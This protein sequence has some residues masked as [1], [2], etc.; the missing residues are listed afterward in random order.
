MLETKMIGNKIAEARKKLNISQAQL[1]EYLFIS[2]QA[3]GKWE[4]G[5]SMPDITTFNRLAEILGVDLNYFSDNFQSSA[6]EKRP[7]ESLI[8]QSADLQ[9]EKQTEKLSWNMS[10]GNWVDANF[11]GLENLHEKFSSSNM[12]RCKFIGSDLAGLL[13][14]SNNIDSCDFSGSD[15]QNSHIQNSHLN[16]NIFKA[17]SLNNTEF[18]RSHINSCDFSSVN[19]TGTKFLESYTYGCNFTG[20]D[21]TRVVI[22]SGGFTGVAGKSGDLERN[23]IV[24]AVWNHTSFVDTQ[25]AD[26]TFTDTLEDCYFE[27]CEFTRVTFQKAT[28]INTF[29]KNN[30]KL[31]RTQFID[32]KADRITYEFLKQG[33]ADLTGITL[34]TP[35]ESLE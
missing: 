22:K 4:R 12:Q 23:T 18:S 3:V 11:S 32:C 9:A 24:N 29:F 28:L 7:S 14:K 6:I 17:C 35:E 33:N 21:F 19:F 27:N 13:L 5:E 20:V 31:K 15:I 30:K 10:R 2:P 26:I 8:K 34:L 16:N 25:I 1:A